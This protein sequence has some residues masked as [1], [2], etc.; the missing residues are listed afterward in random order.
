[1]VNKNVTTLTL[2]L[3]LISR[4]P[5]TE[6]DKSRT[7]ITKTKHNTET[8]NNTKYSKKGLV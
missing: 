6:K 1:M 5:N 4:T 8:A 2:Y 7:D 3:H